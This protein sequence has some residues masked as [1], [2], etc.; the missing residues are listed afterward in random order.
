MAN[1]LKKLC[2][3]AALSFT[4]SFVGGMSV[5]TLHMHQL[6]QA[7]AQTEASIEP[8]LLTAALSD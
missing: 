5:S 6:E 3:I 7:Q 2:G 1:Q 8:A 4:L